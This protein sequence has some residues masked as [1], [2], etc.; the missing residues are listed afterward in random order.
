M[1]RLGHRLEG[2]MSV[3]VGMGVDGKVTSARVSAPES[4]A[5]AVGSC[6]TDSLNQLPI[7]SASG[8]GGDADVSIAFV[9]D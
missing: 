2:K 5:Q 7:P 8:A 6:I 9:P 1:K 4:L 3:H